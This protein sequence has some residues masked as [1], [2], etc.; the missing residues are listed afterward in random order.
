M[1]NVMQ[2]AE[3]RARL[4]HRQSRQEAR[5]LVA[6]GKVDQGLLIGVM[7]HLPVFA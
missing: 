4:G 5:V 2:L 7:R 1:D 6:I 3:V